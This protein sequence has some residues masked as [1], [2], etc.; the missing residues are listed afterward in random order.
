MSFHGKAWKC[1]MPLPFLVWFG[2]FGWLLR[3]VLTK[4][5]C[6]MSVPCMGTKLYKVIN[7]WSAVLPVWL[8]T[9][10]GWKYYVN[11]G[12]WFSLLFTLTL[13]YLSMQ[14][15]CLMLSS[16]VVVGGYGLK[17]VHLEEFQ[18]S[19]GK[20]IIR[21]AWITVFPSASRLLRVILSC[22]DLEVLCHRVKKV[23]TDN[24]DK[25]VSHSEK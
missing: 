8:F 1:S 21:Y 17:L 18:P 15:K 22:P 6:L 25:V 5:I 19:T 14:W 4:S 3:S 12:S 16:S 24:K 11:S 13:C 20:D 2:H 23:Y 10:V 7:N 9:M